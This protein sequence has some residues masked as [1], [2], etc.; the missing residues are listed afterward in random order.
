METIIKIERSG[1]YIKTILEVV[2]EGKSVYRVIDESE[3]SEHE[4]VIYEGDDLSEAIKQ[5]DLI[6]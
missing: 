4:I 6:T 2:S 1:M 3:M 5:F